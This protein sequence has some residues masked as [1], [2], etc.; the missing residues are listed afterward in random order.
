MSNRLLDALQENPVIAAVKHEDGL[1]KALCSDCTV[2]FFLYGSICDIGPLVK[3]AKEAGK[4]AF[5]HLDLIEGLN[6]KDIAADFIFKNT[7]TDGVISTRANLIRRARE[8]GLLT[9]QR[10]FLLDSIAF[11]HI[12]NQPTGADAVEV[13]PGAM[14][15]NIRRLSEKLRQ[16]LIAGGL[17]FDKDDIVSA[18]RAGAVAISATTPEV[19]FL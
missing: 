8:L 14:P 10:Y 6:Q 13:L 16:P 15:K 11:D 19:W 2:L 4:L 5:V 3:R 7:Q 1:K 17:I 18:L 9:V 12:I